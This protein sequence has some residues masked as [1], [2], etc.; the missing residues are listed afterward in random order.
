MV[1]YVGINVREN[2]RDDYFTR[3]TYSPERVST[4]I[5]S[6][7]CT[8]RGTLTTAPVLNVAGL[9]PVPAVSFQTWI[10]INDF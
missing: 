7:I 5:T 1:F 6:P 8:N 9:P 3:D 10:G 2:N 4:L